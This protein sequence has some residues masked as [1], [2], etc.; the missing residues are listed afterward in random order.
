MHVCNK[1]QVTHVCDK[2]QDPCVSKQRQQK[3]HFPKYRSINERNIVWYFAC[4]TA[5]H[6]EQMS[7]GT[8]G[9]N[10]FA[11]N[12]ASTQCDTDIWNE[13]VTRT[14][15]SHWSNDCLT[16][17][18]RLLHIWPVQTVWH[19]RRKWHYSSGDQR[20]TQHCTTVIKPCCIIGLIS[21]FYLKTAQ[22]TF[23]LI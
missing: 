15:K 14:I 2:Y 3:L 1:H 20:I 11:I 16:T 22:R 6:V 17:Q 4:Q 23:L 7:V 18:Y 21:R 12:K 10:F 8:W 13:G 9:D 19:I 5:Y